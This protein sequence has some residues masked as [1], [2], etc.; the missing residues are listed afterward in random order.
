MAQQESEH[1][2]QAAK[3]T[4]G[5]DAVEV[6]VTVIEDHE[7]LVLSKFSLNRD[8][9]ER[10][11]IFFYDTRDL[12]F[13][14]KGVALRARDVDGDDCDS[15]VKIRPV[16]PERLADKWRKKSGFKVESDAVG[17]KVIRSASFTSTQKRKEIDEVAKGDRAIAKLFS[18]DQEEFLSEMAPF[19]V[20]FAKLVPLGPVAVLRWKFKND[21]LPYDLCAEEWRLPDG[22]DVLEVSIKAKQSQAAAAQGAL[23]GFLVEIGI[24]QATRQQTKTLTALKYFA[25]QR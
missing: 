24:A 16:E 9:A 18:G 17:P 25:G 7:A 13:F 8:N 22:C 10:R 14:E 15:T 4:A 23:N 12:E 19:S 3:A 21:G 5:T 20:D 1:A 11:R 2:G 6:K